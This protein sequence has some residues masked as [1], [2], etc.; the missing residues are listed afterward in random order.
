MSAPPKKSIPAK[1]PNIGSRP[2]ITASY[3]PS[4]SNEV[5][6]SSSSKSS[7]THKQVP[8]QQIPKKPLYV[9]QIHQNDES[10][11]DGDYEPLPDPM[12]V[13]EPGKNDGEDSE[14]DGI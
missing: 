12:A 8:Q 3:S 11:V 6:H 7:Q 1:S 9:N 10:F 2:D 13:D 4:S 14:V 5:I